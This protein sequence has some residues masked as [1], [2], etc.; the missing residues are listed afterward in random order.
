MKRGGITIDWLAMTLRAVCDTDDD[1]DDDEFC[2]LTCET[3][4][5]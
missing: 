5:G 3:A 1:D 4:Y 2:W